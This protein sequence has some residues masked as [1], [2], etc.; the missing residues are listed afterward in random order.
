MDLQ[1][2]KSRALELLSRAKTILKETWSLPYSKLYMVL[3]VVM[4]I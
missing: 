4:T 3:A 1:Q 2:L